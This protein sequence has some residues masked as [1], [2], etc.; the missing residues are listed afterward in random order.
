MLIPHKLITETNFDIIAIL[1]KGYGLAKQL[2]NFSS[3]SKDFLRFITYYPSSY[4]KLFEGNLTRC[5]NNEYSSSKYYYDEV[6]NVCLDQPISEYLRNNLKKEFTK[7]EFIKNP[8]LRFIEHPD[9][10]RPALLVDDYVFKGTTMSTA[11]FNM[12]QIGYKKVYFIAN[13]FNYPKFSFE[14]LE[15]IE[16]VDV[17]DKLNLFTKTQKEVSN[18]YKLF[19]NNYKSFEDNSTN[20]SLIKIISC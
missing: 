6:K 20:N 15:I 10:S 7:E 1:D 9:I 17:S 19:F 4:N 11:I 2:V 12:F 13:G 3:E 18:N 8:E 14:S 5:I 16:G